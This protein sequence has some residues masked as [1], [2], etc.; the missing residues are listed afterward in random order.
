M[1]RSDHLLIFWHWL[2][3][4]RARQR[5]RQR[6]LPGLEFDRFGRSLGWRMCLRGL[7][8]GLR[9][10]LQPVDFLRYYE[11][12]FVAEALDGVTGPVLD[13]SSPSLLSL[14]LA[15]TRPGLQIRISNPDARDSSAITERVERLGLRGI[16]VAGLDVQALAAEKKRYQAIWSISV[17]EHI[18][19]DE[20]DG[21]ALRALADCLLPGGRLCLTVMSAPA[22]RDEFVS[23]NTYQLGVAPTERGYFFQRY[24][25]EAAVRERLLAQV[26]DLE[27][28]RLAWFGEKQAGTYAAFVER[29]HRGYSY[30]WSVEAPW[31]AADSYRWFDRFSDMP[32]VGVCCIELRKPS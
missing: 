22:Y 31:T 14:F 6:G 7:R 30:A 29:A 17:F 10:A 8:G 23:D 16:E 5:A 19:G 20:E 24:Y 2:R 28:R 4:V 15:A 21:K 27:V 32:G 18:A 13:V 9:M 11:F 26:P 25:D 1:I 12:A 3:G